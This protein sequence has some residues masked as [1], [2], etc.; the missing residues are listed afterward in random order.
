MQVVRTI[1]WVLL[2]VGLAAFS[3]FNWTPV[4]VTIWENLIVETKVPA[5]V[6][7]AFLLGMVPTWLVHRGIKWRLSRRIKTL[8]NAARA[9]AVTPSAS[10][11]DAMGGPS[12]SAD[13]A[14]F[15]QPSSPASASGARPLSAEPKTL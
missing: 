4:E 9:S 11:A 14:R 13:A 3:F 6:I 15:A 10:T 2:F 8:E 1:F 5:L 12:G 7:M